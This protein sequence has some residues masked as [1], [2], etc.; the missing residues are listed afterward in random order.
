M[1]LNGEVHLTRNKDATY[2]VIY[3]PLGVPLSSCRSLSFRDWTDLERFLAGLLT[4]DTREITAALT[5]L[6]RHG[7]Y[8]VS[9]V[10]LSDEVI[11]EHGLGPISSLSYAPGQV[12]YPA[13]I[14]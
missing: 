6:S 5:A 11:Q 4:V 3:A 13:V 9:A 8:C 7:R 1:R 10:W 12:Y 2:T 14:P